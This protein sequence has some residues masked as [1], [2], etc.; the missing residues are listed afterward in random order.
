M[1][2]SNQATNTQSERLQ[3]GLRIERHVRLSSGLT[4]KFGPRPSISMI[5]AK[6]LPGQFQSGIDRIHPNSFHQNVNCKILFLSRLSHA[7]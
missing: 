3:K 7:I 4:Q 2:P 5:D 6:E 1:I